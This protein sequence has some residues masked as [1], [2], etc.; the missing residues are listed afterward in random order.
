[1]GGAGELAKSVAD[2]DGAANL[3]LEEVTGMGQD[4]GD[5]GTDGAAANEGGVADSDAI[6]IGN[7]IERA[8]RK[9]ARGTAQIS[10][11]LGKDS[12]GKQ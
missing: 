10:D 11:P 1:L 3:F 4:N 6:N 12:G 7:C 8:W 5:T 2:E 9:F